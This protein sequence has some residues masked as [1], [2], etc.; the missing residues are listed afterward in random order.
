MTGN[1]LLDKILMSL[2]VVIILGALGL[3]VKSYYFSNPEAINSTKEER[4]LEE[5]VKGSQNVKLFKL[6]ELRINLPNPSN[7]LR[8]L[9]LEAHLKPFKSS[10]TG[11]LTEKKSQV[12]D[13]II[14]TTGRM[15]PSELTT[16]SGKILLEEKLKK[17]INSLFSKPVVEK[18]FFSNFVIQ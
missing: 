3:V 9:K 1:K 7:R 16:L 2:N 6:N 10:L 17:E 18:I 8:F 13:A 4:S 14:V 11:H 5:D 12:I 15:K